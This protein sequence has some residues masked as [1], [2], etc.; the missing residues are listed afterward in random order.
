MFISQ[1][2]FQFSKKSLIIVAGRRKADFYQAFNGE[3]DKKDSIEVENPKHSDNEGF[4]MRLG[5][6]KFFGAGSVLEINNEEVDKKFIR[7]VKEKTEDFFIRNQIQEIYL[8]ASDYVKKNLPLHLSRDIQE[9]ISLTIEGNY[10]KS[11][12]FDLIKKI[13]KKIEN[14]KPRLISEAAMKILRKKKN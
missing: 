1:K 10:L 11:H 2:L 9:K 14:K 5:K 3:I 7:E 4:F 8:F 12:P 6:G 13:N